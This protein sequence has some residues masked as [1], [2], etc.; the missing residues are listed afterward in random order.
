MERLITSSSGA[1]AA[2]PESGMGT[3]MVGGALGGVKAGVTMV[4]GVSSPGTV[5]VAGSGQL[6]LPGSPGGRGGGGGGGVAVMSVL[7]LGDVGMLLLSAAQP[8]PASARRI[9][10]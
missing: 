10:P 4:G 8:W 9:N 3:A 5:P 2:S 1:T 7:P 6:G